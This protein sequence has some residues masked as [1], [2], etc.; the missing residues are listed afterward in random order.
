LRRLAGER[1]VMT[2]QS[3]NR[4]SGNSDGI[5]DLRWSPTNGVEFAIGTDNGTI[6]R[7][8]IRRDNAPLLKINA[9]EK[10]C[11]AV[12]WH[13]DGKHIASGGADKNIKVWDFSSS[14]C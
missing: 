10:T 7:W 14:G 5:R 12:D 4:F 9:H 1:S 11:N 13:P 6:Q 8:D 2:C 3:L